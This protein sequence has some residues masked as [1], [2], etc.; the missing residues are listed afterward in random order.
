MKQQAEG[1]G[2]AE[3]QLGAVV[4]RTGGKGE[5]GHK[6]GEILERDEK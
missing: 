1:R 4:D 2:M 3:W 5:T 6:G